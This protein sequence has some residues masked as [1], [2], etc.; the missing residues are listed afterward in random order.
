MVI[1]G[2]FER[3]N[4]K[5]ILSSYIL[6]P[7]RVSFSMN[8]SSS[9][10]SK[11]ILIQL[12]SFWSILHRGI[13]LS[14]LTEYQIFTR[15]ITLLCPTCRTSE[16]QTPSHVSRCS[17]RRRP[18]SLSRQ[19]PLSLPNL[20][21]ELP[22]WSPRH[23]HRSESTPATQRPR[24]QSRIILARYLH[25]ASSPDQLETRSTSDHWSSSIIR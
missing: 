16:S 8:R 22:R 9:G 19:Y 6:C 14:L 15:I 12:T 23:T 18:T 25:P 1:M 7:I 13:P 24:S 2:C 5:F 11:L 10:W 20:S 4:T 21:S 17:T 3:E